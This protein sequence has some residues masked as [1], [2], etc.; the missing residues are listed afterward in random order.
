LLPQG[1]ERIADTPANFLA[2]G[3]HQ[4]RVL[5]L[6]LDGINIEEIED[7]FAVKHRQLGHALKPAH[8]LPVVRDRLLGLRHGVVLLPVHVRK[9][10]Q[11]EHR[12]TRL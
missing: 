10:P 9:D 2:G 3:A 8:S 1:I 11:S 5:A 4:G 6:I 7:L 12:Y